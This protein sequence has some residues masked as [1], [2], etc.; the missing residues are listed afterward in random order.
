MKIYKNLFIIIFI[1]FQSS[2][3]SHSKYG[4][5]D[6]SIE[7]KITRI[8]EFSKL[9]SS[10]KYKQ[11]E[12]KLI[13]EEQYFSTNSYAEP[14][15]KFERSDLYSYELL[16]IEKAIELDQSILRQK[17]LDID[18]LNDFYLHHSV[19]NQVILGD[20]N[21]V[22][23]F[24]NIKKSKMIDIAK[25]RL[26]INQ[27]LVKGKKTI[28]KKYQP[29]E[30]ITHIAS[31]KN[32]LANQFSSDADRR[33][34]ISRLI[35][36]EYELKKVT[37]NYRFSAYQ[38]LVNGN[39]ALS[40]IDL[41]EINFLNLADYFS[42]VYKQTNN[43]K[44]AEYALETIYLPYTNLRK[45]ENR[46]RYN[47][48]INE[49]ITTLIE[50]N[51]QQKNYEEMV[52][53]IS[54]NKSR[55]LLEERLLL[56]KKNA[57]NNNLLSQSDTEK[58]ATGL[59]DKQAFKKK[60]ASVSGFLDFYV[61]GLYQR[62]RVS[63]AK[64]TD[65]TTM[66]LTT[67]D[68]GIET[69]DDSE[70]IFVGSHVFL[71][72]IHNGKVEHVKKLSGQ[73]LKTLKHQLNTSLTA[74]GNPRLKLKGYRSHIFQQLSKEWTLPKQLTISPDKWIA[75]HPLNFHLNTQSVRSVNLFTQSTEKGINDISLLGFFNPTLDLSGAEQEADVIKAQISNAQIYKREAATISQLKQQKKA[76]IVHLSMHGGFNS[77]DPKH[78]KL[79]FA[80][81]KRG[82]GK[83]DVN[84]LYA[85]DM[86]QYPI[87]QDRELIF[88]AACETGKISAD[89]N[90]ENE[91][92]GILRPLTANRNKN[93]ILSL[94]K[95]DDEATKDFVT[96]FYQD[97]AKSHMI[98]DAFLF[99][100]EKIK[101]K[102]SDPFYWAAFYLSQA[103]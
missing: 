38:N 47:T 84:A 53:Y 14:R 103:N 76:N 48:L 8:N 33:M 75:R 85:K 50:A 65:R 17:I 20:P 55:M 19:A 96:W 78:S 80:G 30:L 7:K 52:Y 5:Q 97:L 11:L 100:Q 24:V 59:P 81:A 62:Q 46:W 70:E 15:L 95:V 82:L 94:W 22:N 3:V 73:Q 102:Y 23:S 35:N 54:L 83:S 71:T 13:Q 34:L 10:K 79:Y 45:A 51:Y 44:F 69:D 32:D 66:P 77:K 27:R 86:G 91:L 99:A 41:S 64:N 92:M 2:C 21:Y 49:Y 56:G 87:L 9:R 74:I 98:S 6:N 42:Q 29:D 40:E 31:V 90:N 18:L 12:K 67:R 63:M 26:A 68:F 1:I 25:K 43:I 88:A 39:I 57:E 72:Y 89:K 4:I 37:S 101:D 28:S 58:T 93:I 61:G 60:L 16:D 36:G